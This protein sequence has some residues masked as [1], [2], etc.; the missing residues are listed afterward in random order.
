MTVRQRLRI[1]YLANARSIHTQ[2]WVGWFGQRHDVLLVSVPRIEPETWKQPD[3]P[4]ARDVPPYRWP[5]VSALRI[6]AYVRR[7]IREHEPDFV[8]AHYLTPNAW[9]AAASGFPRVI[10]TTWGSDLMLARG[11]AQP[12][13]AW[14]LRRAIMNTGD[15]NDVVERLRGLI[16]DSE[17]VRLVQFGVDTVRFAP[18]EPSGE[19]R[20][21]WGVPA[22]ARLLVS[23]R[24]LRP[25]YNG[26]TIARSFTKLARAHPDLHL[27]FLAY[28]ADPGYQAKVEAELRAAGV[29]DRARFVPAVPHA[30]MPELYCEAAGVLSVPGSD[31]TPVSVLEAMACGCPI[32]A[33]DLPA[34][35]EWI[36]DGSNGWL[37][38]P[39]DA[40]RLA[41][42]IESVL[43]LDAHR[44][45]AIAERNRCI[46]LE[47]ASQDAELGRFEEW[48]LA[49]R[50]MS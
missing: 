33:S 48:M 2:R 22:G 15:S 9:L 28:N 20:R 24:I 16:P 50:G 21:A 5:L 39:G 27:V 37:V 36:E 4:L 42:A 41:A 25:L 32:V 30:S 34:L 11:V 29:H 35:R 3:I 14:A 10:T 1:L 26:E 18:S 7:L 12:L 31:A 43:A 13:N 49:A 8:H 6:V 40:E 45:A 46:V 47:R 19:L 23:P 38:P 44:K 17:R